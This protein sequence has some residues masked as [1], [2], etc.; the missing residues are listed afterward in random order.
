M[1]KA[2]LYPWI[3]YSLLI[4]ITIPLSQAMDQYCL[5]LIY[6]IR[7]QTFGIHVILDKPFIALIFKMYSFARTIL[8]CSDDVK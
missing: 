2:S 4:L 7:L 5:S 3:V 8:D 6:I 1:W